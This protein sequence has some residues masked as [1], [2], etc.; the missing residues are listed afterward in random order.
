MTIRHALFMMGVAGVSATSVVACGSGQDSKTASDSTASSPLSG[1]VATD[2]SAQDTNGATLHLS[3]YLGKNVILIDFWATWCQPCLE[4]MPHLRRMYEANKAKGFVVIAVSMDGPETVAEVPSFAQRNRLT[5]PVV[6]D[7]DSHVASIYN[8]R[9]AAPLSA[10]IDR[11]GKVVLVHEGYN[12]GDEQLLAAEVDKAL[13][14]PEVTAP[15]TPP[16]PANATATP[17]APAAP[18]AQ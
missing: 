11:K 9:K 18:P 14:E 13:N 5:F 8:P 6:L 15:A 16:P 3:Q 10:I 7:E 4:E 17:A 12:P 2:F 1:T